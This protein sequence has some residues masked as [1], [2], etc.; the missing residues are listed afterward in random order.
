MTRDRPQSSPPGGAVGGGAAVPGAVAAAG[1]DT[2]ADGRG[3]GSDGASPSPTARL[4]DH[5]PALARRL[6]DSDVGVLALDYDGTLTEIVDDPDAAR[7]DPARRRELQRVARLPNLR[8]VIVSGR[9]QRDAAE[10]V[11]VEGAVVVGNHGL[12][13]EGLHLPEVARSRPYLSEFLALVERDGGL[14]Y[15]VLVE[16]KGATA[17]VHVRGTRADDARDRLLDALRA[18]L[19]RLG[20]VQL[21]LHPG[22]ASVEVRPAVAWDKARALLFLLERWDAPQRS[23]FYAG[24]DV[25]DECVFA[26]LAEGIT[27]KVG[28]GQT[29]ARYVAEGP[30]ELYEFLKELAP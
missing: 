13:L 21:A 24:D 10:R 19:E 3:T 22:K 9:S 17:T 23:V 26:A 25:T 16:D 28:A 6:R 27:V 11:G 2:T 5:A 7:L 8:L 29:R 1:G 12:E 4:L 30:P 20:P 18:R 15:P 14:P